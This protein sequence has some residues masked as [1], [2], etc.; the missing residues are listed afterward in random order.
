MSAKYTSG[1]SYFVWRRLSN[2]F[3][4]QRSEI[5]RFL[6]FLLWFKLKCTFFKYFQFYRNTPFVMSCVKFERHFSILNCTWPNCQQSLYANTIANLWVVD[7]G[8]IFSC[9][10]FNKK[11]SSTDILYTQEEPLHIHQV[12][13]TDQVMN[14]LQ[15][16]FQRIT[17]FPEG[18]KRKIVL[19]LYRSWTFFPQHLGSYLF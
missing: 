8:K 5:Q 19:Y 6:L 9:L 15:L 10:W 16:I 11:P 12:C 17:D 4:T 3:S 7:P 2:F 1:V 13:A 14:N 18:R